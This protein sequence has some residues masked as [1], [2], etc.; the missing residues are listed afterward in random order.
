MK[1]Q[2][3]TI[4]KRRKG[5]SN[6]DKRTLLYIAP[7]AIIFII[8]FAALAINDIKNKP[9]QNKVSQIDQKELERKRLIYQEKMQNEINQEWDRYKLPNP[10]DFSYESTTVYQVLYIKPAQ[11]NIYEVVT[12]QTFKSSGNIYYD[13]SLIDCN[14]RTFSNITNA[15]TLLGVLRANNAPSATSVAET[16]GSAYHKIKAICR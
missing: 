15:E 3:T 11:S 1:K 7:F 9:A 16:E 8:L 4:Q 10:L 6:T 5:M 13:K 12:S 14:N 2:S